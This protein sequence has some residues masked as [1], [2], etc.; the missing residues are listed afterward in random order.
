MGDSDSAPPLRSA[1]IIGLREQSLQRLTKFRFIG[2]ELHPNGDGVER[3]VFELVFG[4][5]LDEV[6]HR[7]DREIDMK[8]RGG[9]VQLKEFRRREAMMIR[10]GNKLDNLGVATFQSLSKSGRVADSAESE[11]PLTAKL[12]NIVFL[13][14]KGNQRT[15]NMGDFSPND[16]RNDL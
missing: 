13:S 3:R 10:K 15:R 14:G 8:F 4:V 11:N 5:D 1:S 9:F 6:F 7:T 2:Q 16:V 12:G